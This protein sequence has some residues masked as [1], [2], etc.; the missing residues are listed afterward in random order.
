LERLGLPKP[1][2]RTPGEYLP[3]VTAAFPESGRGF[4][5]LTRAYEQ[6]RYGAITLDRD[7]V[8]RLEVERDGAMQALGRARR[9]DDQDK[10]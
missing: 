9:I 6:V 10:A 8:G 3:Q 1:P 4:T 2:A 5:A 7:A